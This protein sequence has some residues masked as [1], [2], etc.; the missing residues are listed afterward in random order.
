MI[1]LIKSI[2]PNP[3][4]GRTSIVYQTLTKEDITVTIFNQ[5]GQKIIQTKLPEHNTGNHT[6][7][8]DGKNS[9]GNE[10]PSGVY[11]FSIASSSERKT[12]KLAYIK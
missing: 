10:T 5:L 8:W 3:F 7:V 11:F 2:S 1:Q 6:F 9:I 12:K 4:N